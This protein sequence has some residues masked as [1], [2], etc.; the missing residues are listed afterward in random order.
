MLKKNGLL[1]IRRV[2]DENSEIPDDV[3]EEVFAALLRGDFELSYNKHENLFIISGVIKLKT[4]IHYVDVTINIS[5]E[6]EK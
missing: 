3:W 2:I 6:K 4:P 1:R 5:R